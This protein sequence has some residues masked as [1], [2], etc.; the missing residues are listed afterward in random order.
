RGAM[1]LIRSR[2]ERHVHDRSSSLTILRV[3]IRSLDIDFLNSVYRRLRLVEDT[4]SRI[5]TGSAIDS[6]LFRETLQPILAGH[7]PALI[8]A[9]RSAGDQ[10]QE[11]HGIPHGATEVYGKC[12]EFLRC[13]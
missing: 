2:L 6:D 9:D 5:G 7:R 3:E 8:A 13:D 4:W 12:A 1:D 11:A 10:P